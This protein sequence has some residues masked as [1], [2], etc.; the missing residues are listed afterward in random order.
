MGYDLHISRRE[1]CSEE[2]SDISAEEWLEYVHTSADLR[3]DAAS[4]THFARWMGTGES[5]GAWLDW[6]DGQIYSKNPTPPLID[7]MV[8]I[9]RHFGATVRGDDGETYDSGSA[10]PRQP[11]VPFW[12]RVSGF[13]RR[14][15][16]AKPL[17]VEHA[18]LPFGIGD[19]VRE[20]VSGREA[21]VIEIDPA[22]MG[23][24]G[25]I[26]VRRDDGSEIGWAMLAH[27]LTPVEPDSKRGP[28]H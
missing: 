6:S 16:P 21:T 8:A 27:G 26:R 25:V 22:G 5:D 11:P 9:A 3:L 28:Q 10:P 15:R 2:G 1:N 24:L 4:G 17:R 19:R 14:F 13:L 20:A 12:A 23:G 7:R 18:P